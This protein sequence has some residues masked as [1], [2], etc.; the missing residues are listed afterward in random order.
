MDKKIK[1]IKAWALI[2]NNSLR[3]QD[4]YIDPKEARRIASV[5]ADKVVRI[6]ISPVAGRKARPRRRK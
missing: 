5:M 2:R 3:V 6:N 4:I 1:T